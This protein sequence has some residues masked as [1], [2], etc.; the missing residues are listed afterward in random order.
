MPVTESGS[1]T[2]RAAL[3]AVS[4]QAVT[5]DLAF[6]GD[7][8]FGVDY[9]ASTTQIV[10]PAGQTS[11]AATITIVNDTIDE[12]SESIVVDIA[13]VTNGVESGT[14]QVSLSITDND[15][16]PAASLSAV[17]T[18]STESGGFLILRG[19]LTNPSSVAVTLDLAFSGTAIDGVDYSHG[20][21]QIV[22][23]AGQISASI[24]ITTLNDAIDEA[25]ESVIVDIVGVTNGTENGTQ[26]IALAIV[27]DDPPP[28][29]SLRYRAVP[30][31]RPAALRPSRHRFPRCRHFS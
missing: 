15:P 14:Q 16:L 1:A 26:Q 29:V 23:P 31:L 8:L 30:S 2:I 7:A 5:V 17:A 18:S 22:I 25:N 21:S 24:G 9:T 10:I 27:D 4:A 28:S 6:T 12:P 19:V 11:G 13:N 3:S 20:T